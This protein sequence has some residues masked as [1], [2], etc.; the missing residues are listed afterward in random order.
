MIPGSVV[1]REHHLPDAAGMGT[2]PADPLGSARVSDPV[3]GPE[4]TVPVAA[5]LGPRRPI[6]KAR[7]LSERGMNECPFILLIASAGPAGS[8][9]A[10]SR[11]HP[12]RTLAAGF[13]AP[14]MNECTFTSTRPG[15]EF[16]A[17]RP[18]AV[19]GRVG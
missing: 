16:A 5:G 17:A 2:V 3:P 13:F 6:E 9:E 14:L 4:K 7:F 8:A 15:R 1:E 10:D 19:R 12:S 18:R 11:R